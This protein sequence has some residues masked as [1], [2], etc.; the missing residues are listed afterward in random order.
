MV[1][2]RAALEQQAV[3]LQTTA[4]RE[5]LLS[6]FDAADFSAM[7][8]E[9]D[10]VSLDISQF[11]EKGDELRAAF[12]WAQHGL[13]A[14]TSIDVGNPQLLSG[15]HQQH[16]V[17][18]GLAVKTALRTLKADGR[19]PQILKNIM[20]SLTDLKDA[21]FTASELRLANISARECASIGFSLHALREAG[22]EVGD[23][24][25]ELQQAGIPLEA[26]VEHGCSLVDLRGDGFAVSE[27][28]AVGFGV[29]ALMESDC[30]LLELKDGGFS[31]SELQQSGLDLGALKAAG[32]PTKYLKGAFNATEFREN[33]FSASELKMFSLRE[34]EEAGYS[35]T[36]LILAN[37]SA[38]DCGSVDVTAKEYRRIARHRCKQMLE[39]KKARW[40]VQVDG[41]FSGHTT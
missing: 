36:E 13:G 16:I 33:G 6:K 40:R 31:A 21:G 8:A 34:L 9:L 7:D 15:L 28:K 32:L 4:E 26:F 38:R 27:L 2:S 17:A 19:P 10:S 37:F 1:A 20:P 11:T 14:L 22:F 3:V 5:A 23:E 41:I 24:V 25:G 30:S 39:K 12:E 18:Q 35:L 29:E